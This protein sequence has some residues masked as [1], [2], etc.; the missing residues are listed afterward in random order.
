[1]NNFEHA[2]SEREQFR[3]DFSN[4]FLRDVLDAENHGHDPRN[5]IGYSCGYNCAR[6]LQQAFGRVTNHS[7]WSDLPNNPNHVPG[8]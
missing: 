6:A 3:T 4:E 7:L 1:M 5:H 8:A 2:Q